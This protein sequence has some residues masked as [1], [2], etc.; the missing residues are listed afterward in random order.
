V[1][2]MITTDY[3]HRA[4]RYRGR[5][6]SQMIVDGGCCHSDFVYPSASIARSDRSPGSGRRGA[7]GPFSEPR[8]SG[9]RISRSKSRESRLLGTPI[10]IFTN[11]SK[12]RAPTITTADRRFSEPAHSRRLRISVF[13]GLGGVA[14]AVVLG[15][16]ACEDRGD[17]GGGGRSNALRLQEKAL[18]GHR[19]HL[20]KV[21]L[22]SLVEAITEAVDD[23]ED[24]SVAS[25]SL[26]LIDGH[27]VDGWRSH[28]KSPSHGGG[29]V[30]QFYRSHIQQVKMG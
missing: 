28:L 4:P 19:S 21:R 1:N 16:E 5:E 7:S 24:N 2:R 14:D 30:D 9:A 25:S 11:P 17:G 27:P 8:R 15:R 29:D 22:Q 6:V 12:V 26:H 18:F 13:G 3:H 10:I 20:W 23:G